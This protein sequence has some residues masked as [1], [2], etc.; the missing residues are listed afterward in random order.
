MVQITVRS[1]VMT[2]QIVKEIITLQIQ[3]FIPICIAGNDAYNAI[4]YCKYL[5]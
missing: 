3:E 2:K 5:H 1:Q 4:R